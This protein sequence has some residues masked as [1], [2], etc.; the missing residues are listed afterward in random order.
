MLLD[1]DDIESLAQALTMDS[2]RALCV[3]TNHKLSS[4]L[5]HATLAYSTGHLFNPSSPKLM[6]L[7]AQC[8]DGMGLSEYR[9]WL[10][11]DAG[12]YDRQACDLLG[13]S[14]YVGLHSIRVLLRG[15]PCEYERLISRIEVSTAPQLIAGL[16]QLGYRTAVA[17]C[18]SVDRDPIVPFLVWAWYV[19][20][21]MHP[22]TTHMLSEMP[23]LRPLI[24]ELTTLQ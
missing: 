19:L 4:A 5:V 7:I 22:L 2:T 21:P 15:Q 14:Y 24:C 16:Q 9:D 13:L 3:Y 1:S 10:A 11:P 18:C 8:A 6:G 12:C 23:A 17:R 20:G